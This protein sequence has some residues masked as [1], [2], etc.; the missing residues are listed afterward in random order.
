METYC[1]KSRKYIINIKPQSSSASNGKPMM[2]SKYAV[3]NSRKC[4]FIKKQEAKGLISELGFK[5]PLNKMPFL[6]DILF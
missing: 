2:I 4:K 1:L 3:C 6:G 5:T